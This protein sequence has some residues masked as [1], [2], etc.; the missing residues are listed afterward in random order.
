MNKLPFAGM[1]LFCCA[2]HLSGTFSPSEQQMVTDI[3]N[4][5]KPLMQSRRIY[6]ETTEQALEREQKEE[7]LFNVFMGTIE[8]WINGIGGTALNTKNVGEVFDVLQPLFAKAIGQ[9]GFSNDRFLSLTSWLFDHDKGNVQIRA[10]WEKDFTKLSMQE[11]IKFFDDYFA[12]K[13]KNKD[14]RL[15]LENPVLT[16]VCLNIALL[17]GRSDALY[18]RKNV[19]VKERFKD[20]HGKEY[21][22]E[23]TK[24]LI[25]GELSLAN[26]PKERIVDAMTRAALVVEQAKT[27]GEPLSK[28]DKNSLWG[29]SFTH[30][31]HGYG[32][33]LTETSK[34]GLSGAVEPSILETF[35]ERVNKLQSDGAMGLETVQS[36]AKKTVTDVLANVPTAQK[37]QVKIPETGPVD[38]SE[39]FKQA[40]KEKV[41]VDKKIEQES[42]EEWRKEE[43]PKNLAAVASSLKSLADQQKQKPV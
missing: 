38:F 34:V 11:K 21:E 9:P 31:A 16:E 1:L 8:K 40:A 10:P 39:I 33:E 18:M 37:E 7:K 36:I 2:I 20:L 5:L 6:P 25:A 41:K 29:H 24:T 32:K 27:D 23:V 3:E 42:I 14:T 15:A 17:S 13:F 28:K 35:G 12:G 30:L 26:I 19:K 22:A 4:A 43:L